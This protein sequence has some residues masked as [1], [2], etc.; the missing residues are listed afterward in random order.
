MTPDDD[1]LWASFDDVVTRLTAPVVDATTTG[2][3][4]ISKKIIATVEELR[5]DLAGYAA[6]LDDIDRKV[7]RLAT[8]QDITDLRSHLVRLGEGLTAASRSTELSAALAAIEQ[9]ARS[10]DI[11]LRTEVT[12]HRESLDHD[13]R[14]LYT[15]LDRQNHL[16][17]RWA[18]I[19]T[20]LTVLAVTAALLL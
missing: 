9:G 3:T 11:A 18:V 2:I 7:R 13:M 20:V 1:E 15:S 12:A 14:T 16:L 5:D 10:R 17:R 4:E 8:Q 6:A 19:S